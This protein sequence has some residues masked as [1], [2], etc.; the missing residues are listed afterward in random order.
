MDDHLWQIPIPVPYS[1]L[2]R[3][4]DLAWTCGQISLDGA[5]T[6]LAPDDLPEQ[7]NIVCDYIE[8]ILGRG[9]M[10]LDALGKLVLYFIEKEAGDAQK[11]IACCRARFSSQPV[12]VP[13]AVP[14]FY[15]DGLL[16]E[17][18]VFAGPAQK[19][20]IERST[21]HSTV[22]I[23]DG[24]ELAWVTLA[25]DPNHLAEGKL[26][27]E[28][29]LSEFGLSPNR[30][31]CE[32]WV[33]PCT[34]EGAPVVET[35]AH[36]LREMDLISD[37]GTLIESADP[38]ALLVSEITYVKGPSSAPAIVKSSE[39]GGVRAIMR[40]IGRFSWFSARCTES[41]LALVPQTSQVMATHAKGLYTAGMGFDAV[42]KSTSLYA[43]GSSDEELYENMRI[44]NNFYEKPGPAST[45]V[46]V[47]RF[48]DDNSLIVVDFLT[49][50]DL[51]NG[52]HADK[53]A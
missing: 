2:V 10:P 52:L 15:F 32:R 4:A 38:S 50:Q 48:A 23:S 28:S 3:D 43:G 26:F 42:V 47:N 24:G 9:N 20:S 12:L 18:D 22:N 11:M 7:T 8:D 39:T 53:T 6:V 45:G 17:V 34:G 40:Q 49:V 14:H 44:R 41:E 16:L 27:L 46:P 31:L 37:E 13:I 5:S 35:V 51:P 25:V 33:A 1:F 19:P 30:R 36:A 21:S 29:A